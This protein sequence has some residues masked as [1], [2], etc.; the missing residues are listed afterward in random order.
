MV[1]LG[2]L[3]GGGFR[4]LPIANS[5]SRACLLRIVKTK[6]LDMIRTMTSMARGLDAFT[7]VFLVRGRIMSGEVLV[8][9]RVIACMLQQ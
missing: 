9:N 6:E 3:G 5:S 2:I 4:S 7:L 8:W 1:V